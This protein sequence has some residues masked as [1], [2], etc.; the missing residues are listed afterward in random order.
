M[1]DR[2]KTC[3]QTTAVPRYCLVN[4]EFQTHPSWQGFKWGKKTNS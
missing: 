2:M 1:G 4:L 3:Y